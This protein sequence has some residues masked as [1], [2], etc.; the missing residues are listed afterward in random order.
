M[1]TAAHHRL[2]KCRLSVPIASLRRARHVLRGTRPIVRT[3]RSAALALVRHP[4]PKPCIRRPSGPKSKRTAPRSCL[5]AQFDPSLRNREQPAPACCLPSHKWRLVEFHSRFV[6]LHDGS[7][8]SMLETIRL[9]VLVRYSP[10][11][12]KNFCE[13][14]CGSLRRLICVQTWSYALGRLAVRRQRPEDTPECILHG[15]FAL[16]TNS[17]RTIGG[18]SKAVRMALSSI[19]GL[20]KLPATSPTRRG[21]LSGAGTTCYDSSP[22][23]GVA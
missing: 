17:K 11:L 1:R 4:I 3:L 8:I 2:F 7:V 16:A 5:A 22:H 20:A 13:S 14:F 9:V 19:P 10:V 21:C 15:I 12:E 6:T 23:A 18:T